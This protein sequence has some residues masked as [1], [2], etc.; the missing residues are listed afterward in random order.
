M[1]RRLVLVILA[2]AAVIVLLGVT[3]VGF[4][5]VYLA[6]DYGDIALYNER[7][8][9]E[10]DA[11]TTLNV[12]DGD[13]M[14]AWLRWNPDYSHKPTDEDFNTRLYRSDGLWIEDGRNKSL[15]PASPSDAIQCSIRWWFDLDQCPQGTFTYYVNYFAVIEPGVVVDSDSFEITN[16]E[17][18]VYDD[19]E[20]TVRPD[21]VGFGHDESGTYVQ[22]GFSYDGP[23]T[24]YVALDG[25]EVDSQTYE[26]SGADQTFTYLI[27]T[28]VAG[29]FE[30]V[31][32][33]VPDD[34]G[35]PSIA[36][37]VMVT[38]AEPTVPTDTTTTDTTA[39]DTGTTTTE[40]QPDEWEYLWVWVVI[41]VVAIALILK[42][43]K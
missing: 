9:A 18:P 39:T 14:V 41:A 32:T 27:D 43:A 22:W 26:A 1:N 6:T 19:A 28:S 31:F 29:T 36:D 20:I 13:W 8:L 38:I 33:V 5:T 12:Q 35:S 3:L 25:A 2:S 23:C 10:M 30:V 11:S 34:G 16:S 37:T 7:T 15:Y 40:P 4:V 17:A 21:D 24:A 42:A